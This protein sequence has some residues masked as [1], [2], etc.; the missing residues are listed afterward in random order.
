M[1][2]IKDVARLAG[3]GWG[4]V[5]RVVRGQGSVSPDKLERVNRAIEALG[6]RPSHAA[7]SLLYG[8]SRMVGIYIPLLSG[9]FYAAILQIIDA[10]LRA[11]GLHMMVTFGVSR[12][13]ARREAVEGVG[14]LVDRGCDGVIVMTSPLTDADLA[15][16]GPKRDRLVALNHSFGSI[17]GQCFTVDHRLGG[18]LAARA[19]LDHAHRTIAVIAGP[20]AAADNV[21]RVDGFLAEL[22]AAGIDPAG[23]WMAE[24]DF[25][26]AGGR[27]AAQEL[28][29]SGRLFSAVFCA[30]DEMVLGALSYFHEAGIRVPADVSV[31]GYDDAP[32]SAY[33]TPRLTSVHIPWR[34]MAR[35]G[36]AELLNLCYGHARPVTRTFP[37]SVSL[38]ATLAHCPPQ[39][40]ARKKSAP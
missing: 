5:S 40:R 31:I 39:R 32:A 23:V 24:R 19:L 14:L 18:K 28:V 33:S 25:S 30:N 3:V 36:V 9:T 27:S 4:T 35:N 15:A 12:E 37:V 20:S 10:E 29:A 8:S 16:L 21:E 22:A 26:P 13:D 34:E 1:A 7:R 17:P 11:A 2:T 6:Y 38:R